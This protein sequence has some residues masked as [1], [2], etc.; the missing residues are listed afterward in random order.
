MKDIELE[1]MATRA[2]ARSPDAKKIL[3]QFAANGRDVKIKVVKREYS[4][5]DLKT[6][7]EL[8]A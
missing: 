4:A 1:K 3:W 5:E 6:I 7:A 8:A 2:L